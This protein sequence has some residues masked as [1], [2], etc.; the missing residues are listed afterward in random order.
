[1]LYKVIE[2]MER[3]IFPMNGYVILSNSDAYKSVLKRI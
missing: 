1:M 2:A 3:F